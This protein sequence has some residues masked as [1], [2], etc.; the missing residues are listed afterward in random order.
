MSDYQDII[1]D[2]LPFQEEFHNASER[3]VLLSAGL[4]AG[5]TY[6]LCMKMIELASLNAPYRGGVLCPSLKMFKRDV[7]PTMQEILWE[8]DI[9][10]SYHRTDYYFEFP[11]MDNAMI[12][13]FHD[14]GGT[15]RGPNLA[16]GA[17][18][19]VTLCSK[20]AFL[21]F[22]G[23]IRIK[24]APKPQLV[25]SGTPEEFNWAYDYFIDEPKPNTKVI[26]GDMSLNH[27]LDPAYEQA[28]RESFDERMVQAYVEGKFVNL[29]GNAACYAFDRRKH[30]FPVEPSLDDEIWVTMDFNVN[31]MSAVLWN[32]MPWNPKI[33][34]KAF[35]EIKLM[36]SNTHEFARVLR[37]KVGNNP[38][39]TV[40]PD[41]AGRAKSTKT[42][43]KSDFDILKQ[44]GFDNLKWKRSLS[45][46]DCL[47]AANNICDKNWM[48]VDPKCK[49]FIRDLEQCKIKPGTHEIDKSDPERSHWL[50]GFKNMADYEFSV[51]VKRNK[52][53]FTR[54]YR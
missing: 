11:T 17:C 49:E 21:H 19:E 38:Y 35:D 22:L 1:Y 24:K 53:P 31:P 40:Y 48:I 34:L 3:N 7:L 44:H 15:I 14:D 5:K 8:N 23:R 9:P 46:R 42:E 29:T 13:V 16:W 26:Y 51:R 27:H 25:M 12:W 4:G 32:P 18:N 10:F 28:L 54:K 47:N 33:K 41:P 30:V 43:N 36:G 2:P 45:V 50:D 6:S 20:N 37:E 52:K 39:I